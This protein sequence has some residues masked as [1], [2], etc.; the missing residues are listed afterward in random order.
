VFGRQVTRLV[1]GL[2][3]SVLVGGLA[4]CATATTSDNTPHGGTV[5]ATTASAADGA[6]PVT[7]RHRFGEAVIERAPQRVVVIGVSADDLDAV[8]GL[9][10]TPVGFV[11]KEAGT[12]DGRFPWLVD[13]FDLSGMRVVDATNGLDV[14]QVA[15]LEPDLILATGDYGLEQ[16]YPHLSQ[17]A[18]TIGYET[19]WGAQSWQQHVRVVGAA[20]GRPARAEQLI[21]DTERRISEVAA[22]H[23][24]LA[25]RTFTAS[26][27]NS[28]DQVFTLVSPDDFA[29]K[30]I[31]QL[32]LR[33]SPAMADVPRV[34]GSPTGSLG[35]EQYDK[36]DADL[37]IIAFTT[38]QLRQAVE[39]NPLV[40]GMAAVRE[41]RYLV[42][43][44]QTISQLRY[45]SVL[46]IPWALDKLRPGLDALG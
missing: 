5:A 27:G 9:G 29:V 3:A 23:P 11:N 8:L 21:A 32:G 25:G 39:S 24:G 15:L 37:V 22:A 2:V 45:P 26:I 1:A 33:L 40:S 42:V 14:E 12:P 19:E 18:T 35:P 4:G 38:P 44:T 20:L 46:G 17:L 13:R 31:E 10:V 36:L 6:F 28:P 41:G 16:E 7:I 34:P 43:D 30:L